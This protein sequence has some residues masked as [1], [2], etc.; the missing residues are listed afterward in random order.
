MCTTPQLKCGGQRT[1]FR[2]RFSPSSLRW[3]LSCFCFTASPP[4]PVFP[5]DSPGSTSHLPAGVLG[6]QKWARAPGFSGSQGTNSGKH[7]YPLSCLTSHTRSLTHQK[8][9]SKQKAN[10]EKKVFRVWEAL[11]SYR[12]VS[13]QSGGQPEKS[14]WCSYKI[15]EGL[16]LSEYSVWKMITREFLSLSHL[17]SIGIVKW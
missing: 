3:G 7:F 16:S 17:P 1:T 13:G 11:P 8:T 5:R 14:R 15:R 10:L 4:S 12:A 9:P 2:N 6:R